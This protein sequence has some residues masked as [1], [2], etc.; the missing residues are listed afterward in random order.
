MLRDHQAEKVGHVAGIVGSANNAAI[1]GSFYN[2]KGVT[3]PFFMEIGK[4][5]FFPVAAAI[6]I[7]Q[8]ILA[9]R[10]AYL[11][12]GK[13]GSA[14]H[15]AVE[16]VGAI[17]ITTAVVGALALT[18]VFGAI[19]PMIFI[20]VLGF[21]ALYHGALSAY[22]FGKSTVAINETEKQQHRERA[23]SHAITACVLTL[24]TLAV[25]L[26]MV[27][28]K[29]AFAALGVVSGLMG[30]FY[31]AQKLRQTLSH[32][33]VTPPVVQ[34]STAAVG[35]IIGLDK[36]RRASLAVQALDL[37]SPSAVNATLR[38]RA[39]GMRQAVAGMQGVAFNKKFGGR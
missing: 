27:V 21:K 12:K 14:L 11:Q 16:T 10:S 17:A 38:Y 32:P 2:I 30:A 22:F 36:D 35:K 37:P 18:A 3:L 9:W 31:G 29:V 4:Y 7:I 23:K 33:K 26:V 5:I 13:N 34:G 24:V 28:G 1:F 15:A 20:A 39:P 25:T 8:M 6:E 19:A